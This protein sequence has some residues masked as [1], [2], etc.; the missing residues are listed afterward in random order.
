MTVELILAILGV[1]ISPIIAMLY[2]LMSRLTVLET[3]QLSQEDRR[4]LYDLDT[5]MSTIW[6]FFERDLPAALHS[7]HT[8]ELDALLTS[9]K[10]G[11]GQMKVDD[12]RRL[13]TL[14]AEECEA[15][16]KET[17]LLRI[18]ALDAYRGFLQHE[19]SALNIL[20]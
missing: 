14:I 9:A 17:P 12:V 15:E 7:P 3:N 2:R 6:K 19:I 18:I 16:G 13:Y 11:I 10:K 1:V 20:I 5:K 8:E 4:C